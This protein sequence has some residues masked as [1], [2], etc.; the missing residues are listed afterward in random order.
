MARILIID[1]DPRFLGWLRETLEDAGYQVAVARD[2]SAGISEF[3]RTPADLVITDIIMPD[4]EGIETIYELHRDH[5]DLPIVAVSGGSVKG[6]GSYLPT[7]RA[8]GAV[9]TLEKPV[10]RTLLLETVRSLLT[11]HAG[12]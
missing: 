4:K 11:P 12:S 2:G 5:P 8:L 6:V 1:D 10:S 9:S 7:A 3:D